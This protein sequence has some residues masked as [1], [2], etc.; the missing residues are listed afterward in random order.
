MSADERVNLITSNRHKRETVKNDAKKTR[1]KSMSKKKKQT[2]KF[3]SDEL[4][5]IFDSYPEEL[6]RLILDN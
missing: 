3:A 4:K 2:M 6:R 5:N 1:R